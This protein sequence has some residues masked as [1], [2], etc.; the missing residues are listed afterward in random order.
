MIE[1]AR[2]IDPT[3]ELK[4]ATHA[5][6]FGLLAVT[7][8]RIGE[9]LSLDRGTLLEKVVHS[10]DAEVDKIAEETGRPKEKVREVL[11]RESGLDR[12]R[13]QI[14]NKKTMDFLQ[15]KARVEAL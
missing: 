1:A 15:G 8:M 4:G 14:R 3:D 9:A 10:R 6:L 7:G 11:S 13:G 5:T 2:Q 12:L